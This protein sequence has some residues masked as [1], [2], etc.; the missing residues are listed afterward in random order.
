[1]PQNKQYRNS[2]FTIKMFE[3][4]T[5]LPCTDSQRNAGIKA[6]DIALYIACKDALHQHKQ[7]FWSGKI[8]GNIDQGQL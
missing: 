4:Y 1:M 5:V 3:S 2:T 6:L 7:D 8:M